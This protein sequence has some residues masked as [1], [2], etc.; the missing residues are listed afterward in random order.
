MGILSKFL[1][2]DSKSNPSAPMSQQEAV[3]IIQKYGAVMEHQSPTP[4]CVADLSKLPYMKEQIKEALVIGLKADANPQMKEMLKVGYLQLADWQEGVGDT[5][6]GIDLTN[7]DLDDDPMK[8][9]ESV[10]AQSTGHEK[11]S[12]IAQAEQAAL[13]QELKELGLW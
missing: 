10:L 13:K 8:S 12:S 6:Q 3:E 1:G 9:A 2:G 5:D 4:G 7:A 11:W